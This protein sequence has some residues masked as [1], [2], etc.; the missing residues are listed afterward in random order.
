MLRKE[1]K[2]QGSVNQSQSLFNLPSKSNYG[3]PSGHY[4]IPFKKK[5]VPT[6]VDLTFQQ[7]ALGQSLTKLENVGRPL[8]W[9]Q[10]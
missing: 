1:P 8:E 10:Q 7:Q 5:N 3:I 4:E 2:K 6:I 9:S